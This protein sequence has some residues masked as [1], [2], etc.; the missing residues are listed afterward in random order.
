MFA[1][2]R[3]HCLISPTNHLRRTPQHPSQSKNRPRLSL[4]NALVALF[5]GLNHAE[6]DARQFGQF[7]LGEMGLFSNG[8]QG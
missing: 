4:Q 6:G 2:C 1:T 8:F 5:V 7:L 3:K